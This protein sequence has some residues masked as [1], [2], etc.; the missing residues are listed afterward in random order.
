VRLPR[1]FRTSSFRLTILYVAI[2]S[3]S[4]LVLFGAIAWSVN[5]F[6]AKQLDA[7]VTNELAELQADSGGQEPTALK[8]VID[9][10][11]VRAPGFYYLLQGPDGAIMGGNMTAIKPKPGLRQ[12]N[13]IWNL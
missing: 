10:L 13:R 6:M 11:V 5:N 1:S 3:L 4:G 9:G 8:R 12:G 7:T 2:I